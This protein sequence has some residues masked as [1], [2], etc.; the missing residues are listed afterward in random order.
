MTR[1]AIK[2]SSLLLT[3]VQYWKESRADLTL[4]LV[5]PDVKRVWDSATETIPSLLE[6]LED[7][8]RTV[9]GFDSKAQPVSSGDSQG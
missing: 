1:N 3:L 6:Q 4:S 5:H 9:I 2:G 8:F 7:E